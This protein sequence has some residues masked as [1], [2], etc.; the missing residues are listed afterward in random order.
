LEINFTAFDEHFLQCSS[1]WLQDKEIAVL[2]DAPAFSKEK[3]DAWFNSLPQKDDYFIWGIQYGL[4][5]VGVTGLKNVGKGRG[6]YWGYIGEKEYW[7]KGIGTAMLH[8]IEDI[9]KD[10]G[11][12]ILYLK[13]LETN[14]RAIS[15][16]QRNCYKTVKTV[17]GFLWMEK[18]LA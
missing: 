9:A 18:Q 7:G 6:E 5:P 13:V 3:Q 14:I 10:K 16:Y 2:I 15:L 17:D 4:M 1:R 8:F 11:L 12:N